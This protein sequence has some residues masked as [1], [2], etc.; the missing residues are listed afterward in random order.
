MSKFYITTVYDEVLH[1][2]ETISIQNID[3]HALSIYI[4]KADDVFYDSKKGSLKITIVN[5]TGIKTEKEKLGDIQLTPNQE[6]LLLRQSVQKHLLFSAQDIIFYR[7]LLSHYINNQVKGV[8]TITLDEIHKTYRG[9]SFKYEKGKD[10][11]DKE[12]LLAYV[13]SI[14]KFCNLKVI[15]DFS[16]SNLV[17]ANQ[18]KY[19]NK[20]Q[21]VSNLLKIGKGIHISNIATAKITYT[22]GAVGEYFLLTKQYGQ[23]LPKEIYSLRFNK[24]DEFNMAIYI[25]RM[26]VINKRWKKDVTISVSTLLSKIMKYNI[27]GYNVFLTY[28]QYLEKIDAVKRAKKV[29]QIKKQLDEILILFIKKEI[30]KDYKYI[31]KFQFKSIRDSKLMIVIQTGKKD[32]GK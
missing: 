19:N 31:G 26:L 4:L 13:R 8:A 6:T 1:K 29:N 11:Y 21:I 15:L 20:T 2:I 25:M 10:K 23:S 7:I 24:I 17:V 22:L 27:K 30:I 28:L 9:K 5:D 16:N 3:Q 14:V 32:K 12:T 18:Y